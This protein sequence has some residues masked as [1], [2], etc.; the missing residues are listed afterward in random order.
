MNSISNITDFNPIDVDKIYKSI[1]GYHSKT[2]SNYNIRP[3]RNGKR[4]ELK[5]MKCQRVLFDWKLPRKP[6]SI[7][8]EVEAV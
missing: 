8:I 3:R 2:C 1:L 5:C 6:R 7:K 4:I